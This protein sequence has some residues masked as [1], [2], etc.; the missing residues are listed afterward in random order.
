MK[1][2][3]H[4]Y[5]DFPTKFGLPRQSGLVDELIGRVEFTPEFRRKEAVRGLEEFSRLW[6]L[7]EFSES[8]KEHWSATVKPPRLGG[9][10]RMGVFAT[11]SPFRP[12]PIGLSCVRL[13]SVDLECDKA[14]VIYVAG[15]DMVNGT[16]LYDIKPYLPYADAHPEA[17]GGFGDRVFSHGLNVEFPQEL[18]ELLSEDKR[19]AA[20]A[21]LAQDPRPAYE[22]AKEQVYKIAFDRWDIHFTVEEERLLVCG[23]FP[24]EKEMRKKGTGQNERG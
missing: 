2:I 21:F 11:R 17:Q 18:L 19:Q 10:K 8:R 16:P 5:T 9:K 6:L 15:I 23:V 7:W 12:N 24:L 13:V 20:K 22:R 14:P 4:I 3:G 1:I